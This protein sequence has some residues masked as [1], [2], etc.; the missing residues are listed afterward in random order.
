M[1][2]LTPHQINVQIGYLIAWYHQTRRPIAKGLAPFS[3]KVGIVKVR[4]IKTYQTAHGIKAT[5]M[6]DAP[7]RKL[8][9]PVDP[10]QHKVAATLAYQ[11]WAVGQHNRFTYGQYRPVPYR[12]QLF[13]LPADGRLRDCWGNA[14]DGFKHGGFAHP[15]SMTFISGYGN[16]DSTLA[17][18]HTHGKIRPIAEL[19]QCDAIIYTN[20]GHMVTVTGTHHDDPA[21]V[22][23]RV[24]SDGHQGAPEDTTH[25]AEVRSHPGPFYGIAI[26]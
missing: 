7:T 10:R 15:D 11:R 25:A 12:M 13:L 26:D 22:L 16:T 6:L 14:T 5:G 4:M 18:A 19:R 8:L 9:T 20:P 2:A 1:A 3:G 24:E 23:L 17:W 21:G